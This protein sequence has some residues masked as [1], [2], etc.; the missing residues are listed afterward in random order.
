MCKF[1]SC[2]VC[3][4]VVVGRSFSIDRPSDITYLYFSIGLSIRLFVS[5]MSGYDSHT[6][7]ELLIEAN[8][9]FK[10][11]AKSNRPL[12]FKWSTKIVYSEQSIQS[13]SSCYRF[14]CGNVAKK[15]SFIEIIDTFE[16]EYL[17]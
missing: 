1:I 7:R 3:R 11:V 15:S 5:K 16:M 14:K 12:N 9:W 17:G 6:I 10:R 13:I 2:F 8:T 4:V